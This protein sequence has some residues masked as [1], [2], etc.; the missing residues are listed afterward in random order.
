M[1]NNELKN[2]DS[3]EK[4]YLLGLF[5]SDGCIHSNNG[6]YYAS[7]VLHE[8]DKYL[9]DVI[10]SKFPFF[11]LSKMANHAWSILCSKKDIVEDLKAN[12]MLFRKST[13]NKELLR[14]PNLGKTLIHH[15]IR[16]YFDGDG[17]VYRQKLGNT[18]FEIGGTGFGLITDLVK[19]LY[20]NKI[21]VNITCKYS[22][23]GLRDHDYY[24]LYA[25]SDKV[26]KQFADY[27]YRDCG[28]L[29][30]KRKYEKLYYTPT[31]NRTERLICPICSGTDTVRLGTRQMLHGL[32]LRGK[33]K[34]CNK[35]FS[36]TAPQGSNT[37]S[38]EGELLES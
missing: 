18:K 28:D 22:E 12:G 36:I 34:D 29:Y 35:Q 5:Y 10:V 2:I 27:I 32:M 14:L 24:V 13:D 3:P 1:Y 21:T 17:S 8:D 26:S 4:A 6:S 20:D 11:R 9:L 15:F 25:S 30:M 19:A 33:C 23:T 16:G 37:L 31:Y 7:I 38:G